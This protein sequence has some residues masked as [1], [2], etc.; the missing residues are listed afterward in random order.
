[1]TNNLGGVMS[2][3]AERELGIPTLLIEGRQLDETSWDE[4]DFMGRLEEFIDIAL[5]AKK[6]RA[7]RRQEIG[8]ETQNIS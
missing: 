6:K 5:E 7:Q 4:K 2:E 1:V 8:S 3:V